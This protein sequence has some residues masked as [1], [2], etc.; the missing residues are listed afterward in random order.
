MKINLLFVVLSLSL[1]F[2]CKDKSVRAFPPQKIKVYKV[3]PK[4]VPIYEEFVGQVFGEKD[5]PIR[6]RVE[7]FLEEIQ[8]RKLA[9]KAQGKEERERRKQERQNREN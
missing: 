9:K 2:S 1:I 4:T 3:I 5:I 8:E 7:G 6:A